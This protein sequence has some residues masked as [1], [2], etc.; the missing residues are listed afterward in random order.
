MLISCYDS[1]FL[2]WLTCAYTNIDGTGDLNGFSWSD[3]DLEDTV[4]DAV[5]WM[6]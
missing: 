5:S 6:T 1:L 4:F 3:V 2:D